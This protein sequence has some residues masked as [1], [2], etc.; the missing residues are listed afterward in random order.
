M[1]I[2]VYEIC[3]H[4]RFITRTTECHLIHTASKFHSNR[5]CWDVY[6]VNEMEG[7]QIPLNIFFFIQ[8]TLIKRKNTQKNYAHVH[9]LILNTKI[10]LNCMHNS[11]M[12]SS[13]L[14]LLICSV[15][16]RYVQSVAVSSI[17][18]HSWFLFLCSRCYSNCFVFSLK[19]NTQE[20]RAFGLS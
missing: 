1:Y 14:F 12:C 9:F 10:Y 13:N 4:T 8:N 20:Y 15:T 17:F 11:T 5:T 19:H 3:K 6:T 18:F 7:G 16:L 2:C